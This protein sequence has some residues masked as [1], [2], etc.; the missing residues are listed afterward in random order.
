MTKGNPHNCES[1]NKITGK[2]DSENKPLI[3]SWLNFRSY[4]NACE[5]QE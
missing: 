3:S 5:I 1:A 4:L 2:E